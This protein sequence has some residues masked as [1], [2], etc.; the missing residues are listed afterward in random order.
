MSFQAYIDNIRA[1]TGLSPA[2]FKKRAEDMG[3]LVDGKLKPTTKATMVTDWLKAEYQLGHG[4]AM[5]IYATLKG[6]TG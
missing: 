5:A 4:H 3:F 1:K 6:K 2:D